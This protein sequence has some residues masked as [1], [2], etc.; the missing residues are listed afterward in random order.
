MDY[1]RKKET[2]PVITLAFLEKR[3]K[4]LLISQ[5]DL[6]RGLA[7]ELFY[8]K[9]NKRGYK[10]LELRKNFAFF[11]FDGYDGHVSQGDVYFTIS[12]ILNNLR[13]RE[14][15]LGRDGNTISSLQQSAFVR[16][17]LDPGNFDRFNDGVIQ[18]SLLRGACAEEL[19][20]QIEP[21][22]SLEM[23]GTFETL[24]KYH[25]QDQ[26]E[27]LIE[28]LYALAS[29]KMSLLPNHLQDIIQLVKVKCDEELTV[30]MAEYINYVWF[31]LPKE[32][33]EAW[34]NELQK[35]ISV[36]ILSEPVSMF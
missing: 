3:K 22:L 25:L 19:S 11:K 30:L 27:A 7:N 5:G 35:G 2:S 23:F 6:K 15:E 9:W 36:P 8:P 16:N 12:N 20:Y 26:G 34:E 18:A 21:D 10:Q 17:L 24:I 1:L 14:P 32:K 31:E 13:N 29:Q 28:F 4:T 33:K